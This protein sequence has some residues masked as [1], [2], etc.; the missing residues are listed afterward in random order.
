MENGGLAS[1]EIEEYI[2]FMVTF[3]IHFKA[4]S[5]LAS[6]IRDTVHPWRLIEL[7]VAIEIAI[8]TT[9]PWTA[10]SVGA[11]FSSN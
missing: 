11:Q 7:N 4:R 10:T 9:V 2:F 1:G 6:T 3:Q 5:P 8:L